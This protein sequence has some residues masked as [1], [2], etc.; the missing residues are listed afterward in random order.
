[1]SRDPSSSAQSS[2]DSAAYLIVRDGRTWRDVF[3][4]AP[5]QVT[6]IGRAPTNRVVLRDEIC[7]RNHCEIFQSGSRWVLRDL[8]SRNGTLINGVDV[9]QDWP[10]EDGQLIR[11]GGCDLGFTYDVSKP[12][13]KFEEQESLESDTTTHRHDQPQHDQPQEGHDNEAPQILHRARQTRY[14]GSGWTDGPAREQSEISQALS[15]LYRLALQMGGARSAAALAKQALEALLTQTSADIGAVLLLPEGKKSKPDPA[16]LRL[17][18]YQSPEYNPYQ[19]VSDYLSASVLSDREALLARDVS[20]DSALATRDSLGE[21]R[22]KS[23]ICAPVQTGGKIFGLV[24]LYSTNPDNALDPDDLEFTLAVA[25]QSAVALDSLRERKLLADGLA[26]AEGENRSLRELLEIDS[27]IIGDSVAMC[28]LRDTIA[29]IAP[30][31]ATTLVRGESGVGKELVARAIHY[32]GRRRGGPFVCMNCAALS[33]S[34]LESEMFGHEKGSF[35]GAIQRN[36]GKF[37]QAHGG[38]LFLDEVGEMSLGVQSKFLRVLE[39]HPFER[40]GGSNPVEVEVRV[41]AATNR[42]LEEAVEQGTFRKDLYFRLHV[43]VITVEPL[44]NHLEDL[45]QLA[46]HFLERFAR[47]SGRHGVESFTPE[48]IESLRRYDWPGNIRELQNVVE[49]AVILSGGS[50]VAPEDI[51]MSD[52]GRA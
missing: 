22:A 37:E 15:R 48:A 6:T 9:K 46:Q 36:I 32:N 10:L 23:V 24:H 39:G 27:E 14:Q 17:I 18:A 34:L 45:P 44:R 30:T 29:R 33:E 40:V 50:Q 51:Q 11:I 2:G 7:S 31:D 47:K 8:G 1:M 20:D 49:R 12:F 42:N 25:D 5:G 38:T 19:K 26:R 4:L 28:K 21:I 52:L 3:R 13:R 41:V 16:Q 43:V 35:T